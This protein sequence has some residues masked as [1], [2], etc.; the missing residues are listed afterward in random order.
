MYLIS[1]VSKLNSLYILH[2]LIKKNQVKWTLCIFPIIVYLHC[3]SNT[4]L[5]FDPD[6]NVLL[7]TAHVYVLLW[8]YL[9]GTTLME[10]SPGPPMPSNNE[11]LYHFI[12]AFD[13]LF[14]LQHKTIKQS[15]SPWSTLLYELLTVIFHG[16]S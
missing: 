3:I 11:P 9:F 7:L 4:M 1:L 12:D 10:N 14:T 2:V 8:S 6:L 15:S 13:E 5:L 16:A